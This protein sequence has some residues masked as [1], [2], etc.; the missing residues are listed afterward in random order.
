MICF[1]LKSPHLKFPAF[2]SSI[3]DKIDNGKIILSSVLISVIVECVCAYLCAC[4]CVCVRVCWL[5]SRKLLVQRIRYRDY[6][7][8]VSHQGTE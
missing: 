8:W 5:H 7:V 3:N 2:A 4:A 1:T 6:T